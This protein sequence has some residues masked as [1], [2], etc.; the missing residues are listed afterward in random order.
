MSKR[1]KVLK[2]YF[3]PQAIPHG[4]EFLTRQVNISLNDWVKLTHS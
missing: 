1:W 4:F 3:L 2:K